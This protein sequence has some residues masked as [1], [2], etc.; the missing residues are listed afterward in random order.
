MRR[1]LVIAVVLASAS[2]ASGST[3]RGSC[4]LA[5]TVAFDPP[6]TN[7]PQPTAQLAHLAGTCDGRFVDAHRRAHELSGAPVTDTAWSEAP[8]DSC[9]AGTAYGFGTLTFPYGRIRFRLSET[10]LAAFPL[11]TFDG[12]RSGAARTA[13]TPSTSQDPVAALQAC[14]GAGVTAFAIDG[15]LQ[16]TPQISG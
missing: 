11:L 7:M 5:G 9:A 1:L 10:R 4:H 2:P 15:R 8:A 16:T 12:R 13:A 6:L 14:A 3:F